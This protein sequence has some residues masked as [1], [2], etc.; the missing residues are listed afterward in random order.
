MINLEIMPTISISK[1]NPLKKNMVKLKKMEELGNPQVILSRTNL[2][3]L[4]L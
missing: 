4:P 2:N 1:P 3:I